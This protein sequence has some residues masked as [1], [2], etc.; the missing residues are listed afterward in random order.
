M[1]RTILKTSQAPPEP[2]AA[3]S[4]GQDD[5][6]P[7]VAETAVS[8]VQAAQ[9]RVL[10]GS[11]VRQYVNEKVTPHLLDAMKQLVVQE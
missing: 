11:Q 5:P 4:N 2:P 3:V 8:S 7:T 1:T 10:H 9:A 6:P